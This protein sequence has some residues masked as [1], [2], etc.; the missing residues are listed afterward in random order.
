MGGY[1]GPPPP[2]GGAGLPA[3]RGPG[4]ASLVPGGADDTSGVPRVVV[5]WRFNE[6]GGTHAGE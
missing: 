4:G 1:G 2:P 5:R 3:T 6:A